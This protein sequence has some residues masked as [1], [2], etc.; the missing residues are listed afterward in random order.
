MTQKATLIQK[1]QRGRKIT[2]DIIPQYSGSLG[3]IQSANIIFT[4]CSYINMR[5]LGKARQKVLSSNARKVKKHQ[6]CLSKL[7][8]DLKQKCT[9]ASIPCNVLH[10]LKAII[11]RKYPIITS[12]NIS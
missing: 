5:V 2:L 1:I 3:A 8:L 10:C 7:V 9:G 12:I 11:N 6:H 4:I